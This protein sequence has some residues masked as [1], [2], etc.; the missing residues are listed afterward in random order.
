MSPGRRRTLIITGPPHIFGG[1]SAK[2][3][4]LANVLTGR[5]HRVTVAHYATFS[6]EPALNGSVAGILRGRSPS[7]RRYTVWDGKD[8]VAVGCWLPELEASYYRDSSRW[9]ELVATHDRHIAVG[10]TPLFAAPLAA[11]RIPHLI[12]CATD[13]ISDRIDRRAAMPLWR[14]I[15][16]RVLVGPSLRR[17]ERAVLSGPGRILGVSDYTLAC[18]RRVAPDRSWPMARL[19]IP[20]DLLRFSPPSTPP[21]AGVIGFAGRLSDP[22]K[23]VGL[24]LDAL[25]L[26]RARGIPARLELAGDAPI[27]FAEAITRRKLVDHVAWHGPLAAADLPAF[28]R[29]LDVF[30]IPSL[31]E[32]HAIVGIEAAACGVP[33]VSTRCGGPESYVQDGVT[34]FLCDLDAV[35]LADVLARVIADRP[36]RAAMGAAC[37]AMAERDYGLDVFTRALTEEWRRTWPE[38]PDGP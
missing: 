20:V 27:G 30:A 8:A 11:A 26:I 3:R 24:L 16:D 35:A 36:R 7:M 23:N 34:G 9:R 22:R 31:Q 28:Y 17:L 4:L 13:A 15:Y 6:A 19:P 12:W 29:G 10:G 25:A 21:S 38:D 32:G 1:V 37:R 2:A 33:I 14:R 18:L 5:G